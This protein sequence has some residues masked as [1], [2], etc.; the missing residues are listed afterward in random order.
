[1][2]NNTIVS[3]S[4]PVFRDEFSELVRQGAQRI[5]RQA[6]LRGYLDKHA[7][8]RDAEGGRAV[9]RNGYQPEREV[10]TGIGAT[11]TRLSTARG[12]H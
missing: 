12:R 1:M 11:T 2:G 5:I 9:V 7:A 6:E 4:N 3:F 8:D 10:L